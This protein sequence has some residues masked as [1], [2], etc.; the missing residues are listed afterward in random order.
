MKANEKAKGYAEKLIKL[1]AKK[2]EIN[3]S[4]NDMDELVQGMLVE[5]EHGSRNKITNVTND[6]PEQTFKIVLAHM[7]E[8]PD[9]YTRLKKMED[10]AGSVKTKSSEDEEDEDY[11]EDHKEEAIKEYKEKVELDEFKKEHNIQESMAKRFKELCGIVENSGKKQL[12]NPLYQE[13]IKKILLK[14]DID[15]NK[16]N[17]VKFSN[18]G[19][20]QKSTEEEIDLYKMQK[21]DKQQ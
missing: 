13:K 12:K 20:G 5:L 21:K 11:G 6:D 15:P 3:I 4:E 2:M 8:I 17:I 9:Y 18:D 10:E 1:L 14:E 19:L 7:D 16:F